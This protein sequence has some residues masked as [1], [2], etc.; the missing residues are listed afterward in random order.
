MAAKQARFCRLLPTEQKI[1]KN[2]PAAE[3][4]GIL[5]IMITQPCGFV[6]QRQ[7]PLGYIYSGNESV[8]LSYQSYN[9]QK[10]REK[11]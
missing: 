8:S 2:I 3:K 11:Q 10:G 9:N 4:F 7:K 1:R 6:W 5:R